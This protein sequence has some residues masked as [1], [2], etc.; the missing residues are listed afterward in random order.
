MMS[1]MFKAE[2]A[3]RTSVY[4]SDMPHIASSSG[5]YFSVR[6]RRNSIRHGASSISE[7]T[8]RYVSTA[9]FPHRNCMPM[10]SVAIQSAASSTNSP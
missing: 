9:M 6:V 2:S 7:K 8:D 4:R 10:S 1:S 3:N 5:R